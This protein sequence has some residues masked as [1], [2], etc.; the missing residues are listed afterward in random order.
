MSTRQYTLS[1]LQREISRALARDFSTPL[2]ISA[3]LAD[4]KVNGSG[5]CYVEL[6]EKGESDGVAKAQA[7]GVIWRSDYGT[8][9]RH[10][11]TETG[12]KLGR[13]MTILARVAVS[14][15]EL[16]GLSLQILNIDPTY[17]IG[18]VERERLRAIARL[19]ENGS[20]DINRGH[21]MPHLVQ[22]VAVVSS[23]Q[24]AGYQDFMREMA[25]SPYHFEFTLF[26]A[27][28]Q[29]AQCEESI[30][31]ALLAIADRRGEFDAVAVVRGGGSVNDLSCYN[32]YRMAL[33]IARFPLPVLSGIGH[34]KDVSV[35]D[36]VA[37]TPL[38]TPTA[39]ATW[40]T[41]RMMALDGWLVN[42]AQEL[43]CHAIEMARGGE[44]RLERWQTELKARSQE[45]IT[46]GK[47]ELSGQ[48]ERLPEYAKAHLEQRKAELNHASE[49]IDNYSPRRLMEIGFSI[50]RQS[51]VAQQ[52][53]RGLDV[54]GHITIELSD[55]TL[56]GEII[57]IRAE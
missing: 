23:A 24:A 16:Y 51:G 1:Q 36:M 48:Q 20:W 56:D 32:G 12:M 10:F 7:R 19:K 46:V 8:I 38:K 44:R 33:Y 49:V 52:S 2:W 25:R 41:D 18:E 31:A 34:D 13:G 26:E 14:Y 57:G 6:V 43:R 37:N 28:M 55:G 17:T 47:R 39:V 22:R 5:H 4:L 15:H 30:V 9:A 11:E 45:L 35:V 21:R 40:L 53:V 50:V 42:S 54:G 3:E 29:G 27:V